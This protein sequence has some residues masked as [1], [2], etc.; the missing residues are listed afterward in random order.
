MAQDPGAYRKQV[1]KPFKAERRSEL[2]TGLDEL[3]S[4]KL[5]T[6]LDLTYLYAMSPGMADH[7]CAAQVD[8]VKDVWSKSINNAIY[9]DVAPTLLELHR[10]LEGVAPNLR[11]AA[12]WLTRFAAQDQAAQQTLGELSEMLR[13]EYAVY[14]VITPALLRT[15]ADSVGGL[16]RVTDA[17]LVAAAGEVGLR[18]VPEFT[19]PTATLPSGL[20]ELNVSQCRSLID[21]IFLEGAPARFLIVDGFPGLTPAQLAAARG[22]MQVRPQTPHNDAVIKVLGVLASAASTP[23][24]LHDLVLRHFVELA[25]A[26][27]SAG[28]A[29]AAVKR[30]I[31][32]GVDPID[33]GR[34]VLQAGVKSAGVTPQTVE[35]N[36]E[37]GQLGEARRVLELLLGAADA[38][39]SSAALDAARHRLEKVEQR[40]RQ[41]R[42][43]GRTAMESGDIEQATQLLA[44]A[45]RLAAD[46]EQLAELL[47]SLPP[48]APTG[49]VVTAVEQGVRLLWSSGFGGTAETRYRVVRNV[50]R[51]PEDARDGVVVAEGLDATEV[52]DTSPPVARRFWYGVS[53]GRGGA[54]SRVTVREVLHLPPVSRLQ[55][56]STPTSITLTWRNP[57]GVRDVRVVQIGPDGA[58]RNLSLDSPESVTVTE[59]VTGST[60]TFRVTAG[61]LGPDGAELA[62]PTETCQATPR[63]EAK[64]VAMLDVSME[65][66][67]GDGGRV[68]ASWRI[69]AAYDVE[70]WWFKTPPP[71]PYGSQVPMSE[72]AAAQGTKLVGRLE[73]KGQRASVTSTV[74]PGLGHY[75]PFTRDGDLGLVG[76]LREFGI[77][78]PPRNPIVERFG[79]ELVVSWDWPTDDVDIEARWVSA[80]GPEQA[81][82]TRAEYRAR[83]GLRLGAGPR[84]TTVTLSS[85]VGNDGTWTSPSVSVSV[86]VLAA[87]VSYRL[88]WPR[89]LF[90]QADRVTV[91]C[92]S[93]QAVVTEVLVVAAEGRYL[94]GRAAA[95]MTLASQRL[96]ITDAGEHRFDVPLPKL[97]KEYWIRLFPAEDGAVRMIDPATDEMRG[98]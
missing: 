63:A 98:R 80:A 41:L 18:V 82:I 65:A 31:D 1:L 12:F 72:V 47:R 22:E 13:S 30:L 14:K 37:S 96:V 70:V 35:E 77:C 42:A 87:A 68:T 58:Q 27:K 95:G 67:T 19:L 32:A 40:V 8:W 5:P 50:T 16:E 25:I 7:E 61:F 46:D 53:A 2:V 21:A 23:Q 88:L 73:R 94:P 83:G 45:S 89:R 69:I 34:I 86:P 59:V 43:D 28:L 38:G 55:A 33:A 11:S 90:G 20:S 24:Q 52:L 75:L 66:A 91:V 39:S 51:A 57:A 97:G 48:G 74:P 60:Y 92:T 71:W 93:P 78:T 49:L 76:Q 29:S 3:R 62:G 79:D 54:P 85:V 4:G 26:A 15:A 17:Q 36:I 10:L 44:E 9:K 81:T 6:R 64:P 56:R 84:T